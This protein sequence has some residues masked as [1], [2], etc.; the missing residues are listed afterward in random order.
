MHQLQWCICY[1]LL[2]VTYVSYPE[3]LDRHSFLSDCA[4]PSVH[5][6]MLLS[7][8]NHA[9]CIYSYHCSR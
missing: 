2:Q 8:S 6:T 3:W 1:M 9:V 4:W 5:M 7:D